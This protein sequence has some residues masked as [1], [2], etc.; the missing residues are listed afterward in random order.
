MREDLIEIPKELIEKH[1]AIELCMDTMYVNECGMLTAIDRTI[2]FRSLVPMET[3]LHEEYNRALDLIL[4][5]YNSAGFMVKTIH[6][7]G[8]Y[9]GMMNKVKDDLD[10]NNN[11]SID[12]SC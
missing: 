5:H 1:H 3:K 12:Y 7:D 8:E 4:R 9:R 6:C 2:K 11:N 10:V